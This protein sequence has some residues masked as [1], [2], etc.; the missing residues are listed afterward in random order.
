MRKKFIGAGLV[1]PIVLQESGRPAIHNDI[2][3]INASIHH[4]LSWPIRNKF[5]N[6]NFGSRLEELLEEPNDGVLQT[7]IRQFT[8][9]ALEKWENRI[10]VIDIIT[11][12][13]ASTK[14]NIQIKYRVRN[15]RV[16]ETFIYPFYREI[17]Y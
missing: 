9:D 4:I 7:L 14:I 16:E 6:E 15:T 17:I 1:F 11:E 3:L 12:R 8:I 10:E 2:T 5:F 13:T